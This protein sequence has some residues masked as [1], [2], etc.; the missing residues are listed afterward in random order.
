M[1]GRRGKAKLWATLCSA[2]PAPCS[3][4]L[5]TSGPRT[6]G[7]QQAHARTQGRLSGQGSKTAGSGRQ[8]RR[9]A[10]E[11]RNRRMPELSS[12]PAG[13]PGRSRP[14][15]RPRR[16]A[17]ITTPCA[18]VGGSALGSGACTEEQVRQAQAQRVRRHALRAPAGWGA[19]LTCQPAAG[20]HGWRGRGQ[21]HGWQHGAG[22][23]PRQPTP[24]HQPPHLHQGRH[25]HE[26]VEEGEGEAAVELVGVAARREG[27]QWR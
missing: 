9:R 23:A 10:P 18:G 21:G 22:A 12:E 15:G 2:V 11:A 8:Q 5:P 16:S 3:K 19:A 27:G 20:G 1:P 7:Q 24:E 6:R 26:G 14:R 13:R 17:S 25:V 4:C